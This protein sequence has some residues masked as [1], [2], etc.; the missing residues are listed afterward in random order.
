MCAWAPDVAGTPPNTMQH[1]ARGTS[2]L[3]VNGTASNTPAH[4]LLLRHPTATTTRHNEDQIEGK[5]KE[6]V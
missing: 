3:S 4:Y 5:Q 6:K 1:A 2:L